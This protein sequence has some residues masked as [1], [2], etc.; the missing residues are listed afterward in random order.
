MG[1]E[2][3]GLEGPHLVLSPS[4]RTNARI[5]AHVCRHMH[6]HTHER[7]RI[8]AHEQARRHKHEHVYTYT[9]ARAHTGTRTHA[10][11]DKDEVLEEP[12]GTP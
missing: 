1:R 9:G 10:L 4:S 12:W 11:W 5:Q 7:R 3:W 8:E 2:V 6:T